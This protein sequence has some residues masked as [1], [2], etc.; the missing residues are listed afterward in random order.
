[1]PAADKPRVFI[2]SS[3]EGLPVAEAIQYNLREDAETTIWNQG[4]FELSSYTLNQLLEKLGEVD[5]GIFVLSADDDLYMRGQSYETARDNVIL[6]LGLSLGSLGLRRSFFVFPTST[7]ELHLPSDLLGVTGAQYNPERRDQNLRAALGPACSEIKDVLRKLGCREQN[8]EPKAILGEIQNRNLE[9]SR[10]FKPKALHKGINEGIKDVLESMER[11]HREKGV[12]GIPTGFDYMDEATGGWR[13]GTLNVIGGDYSAG[14]STLALN[15]AQDAAL[16]STKFVFTKVAFFSFD[17]SANQCIKK[18]LAMDS[19]VSSLKANI[20]KLS[21]RDWQKLARAAGKHSE[22]DITFIDDVDLQLSELVDLSHELAEDQDIGLIII[23]DLSSL[24]LSTTK[25]KD[26]GPE[27]VIWQ[28]KSLAQ[29]L[30]ISVLIT[31][32]INSESLQKRP[33]R[34]PTV[35][36]LEHTPSLRKHAN[37]IVLFHRPEQYGITV[38]KNGNST[39]GTAEIILAKN[40]YGPEGNIPVAFMKEYGRIEQFNDEYHKPSWVSAPNAPDDADAP[41]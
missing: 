6:E 34:R 17:F 1:M 8:G 15:F 39:E 28:L 7:S 19:G 31:S 24:L 33:E 21:D 27:Q 2:G 12:F 41:F 3:K 22:M 25:K 35:M 10:R 40:P 4:I 30:N 5:F 29:E 13:N 18:L 37:V 38:D 20:G 16:D 9:S 26:I 36:D 11:V 32:K 23:D 14:S